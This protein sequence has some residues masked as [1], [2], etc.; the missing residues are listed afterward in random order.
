MDL[1][2]GTSSLLLGEIFTKG[3]LPSQAHPEKWNNGWSARPDLVYLTQYWAAYYAFFSPARMSEELQKRHTAV[4]IKVT[5]DP[6]QVELYPDEDFIRMCLLNPATTELK[7]LA[8][9]EFPDLTTTKGIDPTDERWKEHGINWEESLRTTGTVSSR[10]IGPESIGGFYEMPTEDSARPF[11]NANGPLRPGLVN[12]LFYAESF[13]AALHELPYAQYV[14]EP[15]TT[16]D[17]EPA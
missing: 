15:A 16:A 14:P 1:F 10:G 5:V 3:L 8:E 2:H 9:A 13:R 7:A 11:V 4:I 17:E 12:A 6:E